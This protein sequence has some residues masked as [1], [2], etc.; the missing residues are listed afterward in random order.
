MKIRSSRIEL[1]PYE[2]IVEAA[3]IIQVHRQLDQVDQ[4]TKPT[5]PVYQQNWQELMCDP[6][7][8]TGVL[9]SVS[10]YVA[11]YYYQFSRLF[12]RFT[13][14]APGTVSVVED[15]C[16]VCSPSYFFLL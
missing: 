6:F 12:E 15:S 8:E 13:V 3:E 9:V 5:I 16:T 4:P 2:E 11:V 10:N 1:K 14:T 7:A